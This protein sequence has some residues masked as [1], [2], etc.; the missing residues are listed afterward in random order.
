[1]VIDR[2]AVRRQVE[3][4]FSDSNLPRDKF[5]RA[6]TEENELGYVDLS[7]LLSFNRL[8][9]LGA[10]SVGIIAEAVTKSELVVLD[11]T[12]TRIRRLQPLPEVPEWRNRSIYAKGWCANGA[13]PSIESVSQ[14]FS[15]S[16]D[17][18]SVRIRRWKDEAGARHFKGSVFV[19]FSTAEAAERAAAEQYAVNTADENGRKKRVSLIIMTVDGYFD[20]KRQEARERRARKSSKKVVADDADGTKAVGVK[21]E[22]DKAEGAEEEAAKV[23]P[24]PKSDGVDGNKTKAN[25]E[26]KKKPHRDMVLGMV[27]RFENFGPS[28]SR[29]DIREAFEPFGE[30]AWVDFRRDDADGHIRFNSEGAAAAAQKSMSESK[31]LFGN[32]LPTFLVLSGE[33]EV[34]YWKELWQKQDSVI[35]HSRKRRRDFG[36][37]GRGGKRRRGGRGRGRG[38]GGKVSA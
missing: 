33:A 24:N 21:T 1:M 4:Y 32:K 16:G 3:Y 5:L 11:D 22:A 37:Y 23:E 29:E 15:P 34:A 6:K 2:E 13:E 18:L 25:G 10:T 28:V 12:Q 17:V 27:L 8:A 14:L 36:G 38:R 9:K 7:I 19:E 35:Q 26:T 20:K 30:I 31:T